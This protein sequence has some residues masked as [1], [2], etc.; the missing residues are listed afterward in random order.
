MGEIAV[1]IGESERRFGPEQGT[2]TIGRA[3]ECTVQCDAPA[4]SSHH[5]TLAME[6]GH[7]VYRDHSHNGSTVNG[8]KVDAFTVVGA[9][10]VVLGSL[11]Q[12]VVIDLV[13]VGGVV[14][15]GAAVA[16]PARPPAAEGGGSIIPATPA[17][18][19][20]EMTQTVPQE[21]L[22]PGQRTT[23]PDVRIHFKGGEFV[24][25]AGHQVR[26]GREA[27]NDIVLD[28]PRVSRRHATLDYTSKG[29]VLTDRGSARGLTFDGKPTTQVHLQGETE[30]WFGSVESG[31][32]VIFHGPGKARKRGSS[33]TNPLLLIGAVAMTLVIAITGLVL[34]Q[35][36]SSTVTAVAAP[37]DTNK[38]G[39]DLAALKKATVRIEGRF[40]LSPA[41][42]K[43]MDD[44]KRRAGVP[45]D[46]ADFNGSGTIISKD[47]LI[48]T[49]AHIA[50]PDLV[51]QSGG[52]SSP[53]AKKLMVALNL[54]GSDE[55]LTA[56][57]PATVVVSDPGLDLAIIRITPGSMDLTALDIE[58]PEAIRAGEEIFVL[59]F[60]G[61]SGS[62]GV[63]V[64][65]GVISSFVG[66]KLL[67]TERAWI[68]TDT[69]IDQGNSGGLAASA[70]GR[71]IG[72]PTIVCFQP[73]G[74]SFE[75]GPIAQQNRIRPIEVGVD[76]IEAARSGTEYRPAKA[77][78]ERESCGPT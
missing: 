48:L 77:T 46:T 45:V 76:L 40:E 38:P 57:E 55:P 66:D 42:Q 22:A 11:G 43:R 34:V 72:V 39:L 1:W 75:S 10:R 78:S 14:E 29:W 7:W 74:E 47:G 4:I 70:A 27:D 19:L 16:I 41:Q 62:K 28:N 15:S 52:P 8:T 25:H 17:P 59:G 12:G 61:V 65:R 31:T 67:Q 6:Q 58:R 21:L 37:P 50:T 5:A 68:N 51:E 9:V 32:R 63:N 33:A 36:S 30:V 54:A 18:R 35:R 60:P 13:P 53:R 56:T 3:S 23:G 26:L 73:V 69:K 24:A 44:A 20:A 71:L 2:I 64:T 49:N